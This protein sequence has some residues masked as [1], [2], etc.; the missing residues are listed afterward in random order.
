[1]ASYDPAA[2][3]SESSY[4]AVPPTYQLS[5]TII[6]VPD[7]R[8]EWTTG[9]GT[10]PSVQSLEDSYGASWRPLQSERIF[11]SRRKVI[12]DEIRNRKALNGNAAAAYFSGDNR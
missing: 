3:A 5:R 7:L 10:S 11:Y 2:A 8:G 12:I 4:P 9:S 6:T 1:M